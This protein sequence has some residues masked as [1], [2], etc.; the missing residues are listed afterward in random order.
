MSMLCMSM[1]IVVCLTA[2]KCQVLIRCLENYF[3]ALQLMSSLQTEPLFWRIYDL[4]ACNCYCGTL[5]IS[6]LCSKSSR[7]TSVSWGSLKQL[8]KLSSSVSV[9][10][11]QKSLRHFALSLDGGCISP[12]SAHTLF[13]MPLLC[14]SLPSSC[15]CCNSLPHIV[16]FSIS[17]LNRGMMTFSLWGWL[18]S[19]FKVPEGF[20]S[21]ESDWDLKLFI[22]ALWGWWER[23]KI[24][25][26]N[27]PK[28]VINLWESFILC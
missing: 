11:C 9:L 8:A 3:Q 22:W 15:H 14:S 12:S 28:T 20:R 5:K 16:Y 2:C 24:H 17:C 18:L 27:A 10:C 4:C 21:L 7:L 6:E 26:F 1:L 25:T 19:P 23:K 13:P